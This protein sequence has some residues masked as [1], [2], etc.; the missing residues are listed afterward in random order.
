MAKLTVVPPKSKDTRGGP[1]PN[2]TGAPKKKINLPEFTALCERGATNEEIAA[3][4]KVSLK[5][6][7]RRRRQKA[8]ADAFER[9]HASGKLHVRTWIWES[10]KEGSVPAR[11]FLSKAVLGLSD[12]VQLVGKDGGAI[13]LD[14]TH[15]SQ[16][17]KN[18]SDEE[19]EALRGL[20]AK[21]S[22]P[23]SD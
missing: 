12:K 2:Q 22:E 9:G 3:F 20:V 7:E 21:T 17:L 15:H 4:F 16:N 18:L 8:Y 19:L 23:E 5:T 13:E 1:R 14:V 10:A 11:I 6:I